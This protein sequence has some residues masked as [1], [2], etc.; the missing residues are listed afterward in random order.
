MARGSTRPA[1]AECGLNHLTDVELLTADWAGRY[2]ADRLMHRLGR[3]P[4][5]EYE[6]IYYATNTAPSEA[7]AL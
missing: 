7:V 2:N 5:V 3:F 1:G 6:A 4:P